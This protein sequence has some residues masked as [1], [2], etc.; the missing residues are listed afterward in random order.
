MLSM[1]NASGEGGGGGGGGSIAS[2]EGHNLYHPEM[3]FGAEANTS[4]VEGLS[5]MLEWKNIFATDIKELLESASPTLNALF[6][7]IN[8]S[9]AV[10]LLTIDFLEKMK[11]KGQNILGKKNTMF[12]SRGGG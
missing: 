10:P 9:G 12:F 4:W 8:I 3:S 5:G 1:K 11:V 7:R 2:S 6:F